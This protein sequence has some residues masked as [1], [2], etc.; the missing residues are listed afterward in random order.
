MTRMQ[1]SLPVIKCCRKFPVHGIVDTRCSSLNLL[2][3]CERC[4][5]ACINYST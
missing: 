2:K 5:I 3:I 1:T 4:F